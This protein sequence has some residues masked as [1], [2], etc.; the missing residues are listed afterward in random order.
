LQAKQWVNEPIHHLLAE[1][2]QTL[3]DY[4]PPVQKAATFDFSEIMNQLMSGK[5]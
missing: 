5:Q 2:V 4:Y 1:H 3:V